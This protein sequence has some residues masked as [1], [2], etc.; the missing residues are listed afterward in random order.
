MVILKFAGIWH[1]VSCLRFNVLYMT[2]FFHL[3]EMGT[4]I[5][6]NLHRDR[7]VMTRTRE[8]VSGYATQVKQSN[9]GK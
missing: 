6:D 2:G 5:M 7:E 4:A 3:E 9:G 1:N 8:R